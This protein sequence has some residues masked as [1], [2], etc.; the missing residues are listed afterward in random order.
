M[1]VVTSFTLGHMWIF[2]SLFFRVFLSLSFAL[3][4]V[5][6]PCASLF[7]LLPLSLALSLS[8]YFVGVP[9][10]SVWLLTACVA[11]IS[12]MGQIRVQ[13]VF[14]CVLVSMCTQIH[15]FIPCFTRPWCHAVVYQCLDCKS[16]SLQFDWLTK[17]AKTH[18][19][20]YAWL[21]VFNIDHTPWHR[22]TSMQNWHYQQES[23]HRFS[24]HE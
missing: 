18:Q 17:R 6:S 16:N 19:I 8:V 1:G 21:S 4:Y 2:S 11:L 15:T 12:H 20:T 22:Q 23:V 9:S 14:M 24:G 7:F 3:V 5:S 13:G 10:F